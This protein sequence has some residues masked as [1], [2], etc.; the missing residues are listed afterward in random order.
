MAGLSRAAAAGRAEEALRKVQISDPGRVLHSYPHQLSG[1]MLQRVV[2]AMALA[3][4]PN[5]LILDEPT[6][7]LD[8]TVEAEILELVS[9]LREEFHTSI[10]FISRTLAVISTTCERA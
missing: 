7:A 8:S 6:T 1:G 3:S 9:S 2:I 4:E 10:L 5:L